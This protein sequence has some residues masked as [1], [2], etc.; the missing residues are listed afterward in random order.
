MELHVATIAVSSQDTAIWHRIQPAM[1]WQ[2]VKCGARNKATL[3][4]THLQDKLTTRFMEEL[5]LQR[6][7]IRTWDAIGNSHS[8]QWAI[9]S[10]ASSTTPMMATAGITSSANLGACRNRG[11]PQG[12]MNELMITRRKLLRPDLHIGMRPDMSRPSPAAVKQREIFLWATADTA[13]RSQCRK[14]KQR[15]PVSSVPVISVLLSGN[16]DAGYSAARAWFHDTRS[17]HRRGK[18]IHGWELSTAEARAATW[19]QPDAGLS[20]S[21]AALQ[22]DLVAVGCDV[23]FASFCI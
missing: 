15:H 10:P 7:I 19:L 14:L 11:P 18:T 23:Y 17:S 1:C 3:T 12:K 13:R 5:Q 22:L 21:W 8:T 20:L 16:R 4:N 6:A 9:S 2:W